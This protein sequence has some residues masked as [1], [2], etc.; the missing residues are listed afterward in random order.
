MIHIL[1]SSSRVVRS[2][3]RQKLHS[4]PACAPSA[5]VRSSGHQGAT[6]FL[7]P[8]LELQ[9][10]VVVADEGVH[11][12]VEVERAPQQ[13]A[14][15]PPELRNHHGDQPVGERLQPKESP[16]SECDFFLCSREVLWTDRVAG[17]PHRYLAGQDVQ[18]LPGLSEIPELHTKSA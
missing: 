7:R 16:T 10:H 13:Q 11:G 9:N 15:L 4:V 14:V 5:A 1:F 8:P 17:F 12:A 6:C 3:L 18:V 2:Q